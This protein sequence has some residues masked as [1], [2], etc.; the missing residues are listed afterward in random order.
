MGECGCMPP[1]RESLVPD[2][3]H[4]GHCTAEDLLRL[5]Q[6]Q[7]ALI[8][9]NVSDVVFA[10]SVTEDGRFIFSSVNRRF[11]EASGLTEQQVVGRYAEEVILP[12]AHALVLGKYR[13]AIRTRKA[14]SWE[15][16][17]TYPSGEKVSQV[18][19]APVIDVDNACRHLIGTVHDVT[20][21]RR[22]HLLLERTEERWRLALEGSGAGVWDWDVTGRAA[23]YSEQWKRLLGHQGEEISC[24]LG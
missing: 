1:A 18:T 19:I 7:L 2:H 11:L 24:D 5:R 6:L 8:F 10:L 22:V 12:A 20:Q 21:Y 9:D 3:G 23:H 17:A 15:E 13:E 14:V 16:T 4:E